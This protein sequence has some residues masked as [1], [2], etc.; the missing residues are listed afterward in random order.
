MNN[1]LPSSCLEMTSLPHLEH[2]GIKIIMIAATVAVPHSFTDKEF[3]RFKYGGCCTSGLSDT[4]AFL[5]P[6]RLI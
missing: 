3:I 6:C 4:K 5:K 1:K 2:T